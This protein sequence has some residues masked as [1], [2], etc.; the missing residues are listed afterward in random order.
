VVEDTIHKVGKDF[1]KRLI[2]GLRYLLPESR[3]PEG[4]GEDNAVTIDQQP[5][6]GDAKRLNE[7]R[8]H[9]L[10]LV[11]EWHKGHP[12]DDQ[13]AHCVNVAECLESALDQDSVSCAER[14]DM[15][16]AALGHDL[17]ED[18]KIPHGVVIK[19]FGPGVH[20]LIQ[21][22]TEGP[23]GVPAYV[24]QVASG[25]EEARLIK[26]CDGIDNYGGL[27]EH[28]LL[29]KEPAKRVRT[30]RTHMEPMFTRL[31]TIPFRQYPKAGMW[32]SKLVAEKRE[33]FWAVVE[34]L[35]RERG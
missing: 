30:V 29:Q 17:Y 7:D 33:Q 10:A 6:D 8:A 21:T 15:V 28:G 35:L 16:L 4:W 13:V 24:D 20:H 3:P 31:E 2:G 26:I 22:L 27:V 19:D 23:E 18:S 5:W 34:N 9:F 14:R 32:L 12:R 1:R 11:E 25:P